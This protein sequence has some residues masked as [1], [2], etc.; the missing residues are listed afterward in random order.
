MNNNTEKQRDP[1]FWDK[2]IRAQ[3]GTYF[4]EGDLIYARVKGFQKLPC[5]DYGRYP[6]RQYLR[7]QVEVSPT[8][9][10]N[11]A[12]KLQW[13]WA[14]DYNQ[15]WQEIPTINEKLGWNEKTKEFTT[16]EVI[17]KVG[18]FRGSDGKRHVTLTHLYET[19]EDATRGR[20]FA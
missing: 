9:T 12:S 19:M 8:W 10:M 2:Q 1:S 13:D 16:P 5:K 3:S 11:Y 14:P 15:H 7:M 18:F 20:A 4:N 17:A 6:V